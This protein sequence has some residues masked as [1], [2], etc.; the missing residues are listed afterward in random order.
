MAFYRSNLPVSLSA[1]NYVLYRPHVTDPMIGITMHLISQ[2]GS[3]AMQ[4][5]PCTIASRCWHCGVILT[6][7][8]SSTSNYLEL[9]IWDLR[10]RAVPDFIQ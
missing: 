4:Y 5:L 8:N 3:F 10:C 7:Y 9:R 6:G 2:P 1:Y